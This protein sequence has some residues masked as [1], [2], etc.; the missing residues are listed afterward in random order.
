MLDSSRE[1][2]ADTPG[3]DQE[4]TVFP[5]AG[6]EEETVESLLTAP[7]ILSLAKLVLMLYSFSLAHSLLKQASIFSF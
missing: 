5:R 7:I 3:W 2:F 6:N 4:V 1:E